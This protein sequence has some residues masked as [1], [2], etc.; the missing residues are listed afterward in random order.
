MAQ[1][2]VLDLYRVVAMLSR[3][4]FE[5]VQRLTDELS[6]HEVV[7]AARAIVSEHFV[8]KDSPGVLPLRTYVREQKPE[9]PPLEIRTFTNALRDLVM[10]GR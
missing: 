6:D 2:H 8:K 3:D 9:V 7:Q 5:L 4:E 10:A 1:H